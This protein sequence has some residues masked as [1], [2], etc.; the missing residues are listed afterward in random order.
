MEEHGKL[1]QL[2]SE[3]DGDGFRTW[4][5]MCLYL[6][7][8]RDNRSSAPLFS[9]S[10]EDFRRRIASG[11]AFVTFDYGIDGVSI[12][13]T[14]Y[15]RALEQL[16]AEDV[17]GDGLPVHLL[18]A[19]FKEEADHILDGHWQRHVLNDS[20]S[21]DA[22]HGYKS[23]CFTRLQRGSEEYNDLAQRIRRETRSLVEELGRYLLDHRIGLVIPVNVCSNPGNLSL[24]FAL[25]MVSEALQIPVFNNSHDFYWEGGA[26]QRKHSKGSPQGIRDHFFRNEHVGEVFSMVETLYPWS[27][28][29]WYQAVINDSQMNHLIRRDGFNPMACGVLPTAVDTERYRPRNEKERH[30][31]LGNL[32]KIFTGRSGRLRAMEP[33]E[34]LR[35]LPP[36]PPARQ[37]PVVLG[38][39]GEDVRFMVNNI[40]LLQPTRILPRKRIHL[41][42]KFIESLLNLPEMQTHFFR[43]EELQIT[44]LISGPYTP[45][46]YPHLKE[47]VRRFATL[48]ARVHHELADRI[49]L[50]FCFGSETNPAGE[51]E[52]VLI[53]EIYAVANLVMLPSLQEGRGLPIIEAA[54]SGTPVL[55]HRYDP[56]AVYSKVI[57]ED[58]QEE[59]RLKVFEFSG[60]RIPPAIVREFSRVLHDPQMFDGTAAHNR[61]AARRRFGFRA[62]AIVFNGMLHRLWQR[63]A[64]LPEALEEAAGAFSRA[65]ELTGPVP[66]G[67]AD[68]DR[69]S[70]LPGLNKLEYMIRLKSLIDPSYFRTE[71]KRLRGDLYS[72][73]KDLLNSRALVNKPGPAEKAR[74][75]V[76]LEA[77]FLLHY[78]E[79]EIVADHSLS[80]RHRHRRR[81]P[82]RQITLPELKGVAGLLFHDVFG[83]D[84]RPEISTRTSGLQKGFAGGLAEVMGGGAPA[85]DDS[86]ELFR[87][88]ARHVPLAWFPGARFLAEMRLLVLRVLKNRLGIPPGQ[89]LAA[90]DLDGVDPDTTGSITM[91]VRCRALDTEM[92]RDAVL[93]WLG[94]KANREVE[95][96]YEHGFFRVVGHDTLGPGVHL[97]QVGGEARDEL[98]R[99]KEDGGVGVAFGVDNLMGLDF[100]DLPTFRIGWNALPEVAA[101]LGIPAGSNW[102]LRVPAGLRPD[103]SYPTPLQSPADLSRTLRGEEMALCVERFGEEEVLNRLRE[104]AVRQGSP[105]Q[106][107]LDGLLRRSDG[108]VQEGPFQ[109]QSLT[110]LHSDGEPW[111]GALVRI[112]M[113]AGMPW[114]FVGVDRETF[115]GPEMPSSCTLMNLVEM[116]EAARGGRVQVAWN[117][118]YI[119]NPELVGKLG[120]DEGFIG[121]PLGLF[122]REG[123]VESLP[124]FNKST[125]CFLKDGGA[126]IRRAGLSR[127]LSIT[128]GD[129]TVELRPEHYESRETAGPSWYDLLSK[130]TVL[131][132]AGR[133]IYHLIGNRIF[134]VIDGDQD[135]G[136]L[137]PVG[138]TVSLPRHEAPDEWQVDCRVRFTLP[139]WDDVETA[140]EAGPGLVRDGQ[141]RISMEEEGWTTPRSIATQAARLD[142]THM[143][144]PKIAAG[145]TGDGSI[146]VAAVNGRI[147]E[148]V[149]ATHEDLA[150]ILIEQGA[151]SAMG[152]DPGGSATLI[153]AGRQLNVSPYNPAYEENHLSLPPCPRF[154]GN[155]ILAKLPDHSRKNRL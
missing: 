125:F 114:S 29:L 2:L 129:A 149:G 67:L 11:V 42:F 145:L 148:S 56:E 43:N 116:E 22:W 88:F 139:G 28:P 37:D 68:C 80:Y 45:A 60:S 71:E 122:I 58:L 78:G 39:G 33:D 70:Y 20:L 92:T 25:T 72:F 107:V 36:R 132:A 27:S 137:C 131:P 130:E 73:G 53:E 76:L 1:D 95:L 96:L 86:Q 55:C 74:F 150:R 99:I 54:A 15:A 119:L 100:I 134:R 144:G 38:A 30:V 141:V 51:G 18:G 65:A 146:V 155:G 13:I 14:K 91:F 64:L 83:R 17:V 81:Y 101:W 105:V 142:F 97:G 59:M 126:E 21:F 63:N 12:E 123:V 89:V 52:K 77:L 3:L 87:V 79:E 110:G 112:P 5:D 49:F 128:A 152:F 90:G 48:R 127:G 7:R 40:L 121:S 61:E 62:L 57:G 147:R 94:K 84:I 98:V 93:D 109:W 16:L 35:H 44:L 69:R 23:L 10:F 108:E 26:P 85:I 136:Q 120:L 118:G 103:V 31:I 104:D 9:G 19:E 34:W 47:L 106:Q 143:R 50:A 102:V 82:Y 4:F 133:M 117:G 6:D 151:V 41:D 153:A 111:S 46:H 138:L 32:E 75:F 8:M 135:G 113:G 24:S 140:V 154:V 124:L 115:A 66:A